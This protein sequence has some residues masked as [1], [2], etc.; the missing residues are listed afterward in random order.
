MDHSW[1]CSFEFIIWICI[2]F[3]AVQVLCYG[4]VDFW[5]RY[6]AFSFFF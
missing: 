2:H 5:R 6:V 3:I 4:I 1:H